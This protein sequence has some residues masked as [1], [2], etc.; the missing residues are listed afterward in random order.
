MTRGQILAR[1]EEFASIDERYFHNIRPRLFELHGDHRQYGSRE[2]KSLAEHLD[3]ACQFVLTVSRLANFPETERRCVLCAAA[4][5]DLNKIDSH[6]RSVKDLARTP[7]YIREQL[8]VLGISD[9]VFGDEIELLRKL[10]ERHSAHNVTDGAS[11]LPEPPIVKRLAA[12]VVAADLFDLSID[13]QRRFAKIEVELAV[14][15]QRRVRLFQIRISEDRG[16]LTSLLLNACQEIVEGYGLHTLSIDPDGFIVIGD[17]MPAE[18]LIPEIANRW[19]SKIDGV[20]GGSVEQ[21]VTAS[22]DGIKVDLQAV[23]LNPGDAI[24]EVDKRLLNKFSGYKAA[25]VNEDIKKWAAKAG[26]KA[27]DDAIELG[28]VPVSSAEEFAVSEGLK[29]CY[30]SYRRANLS[31]DEVWDRIS[32][33]TNMSSEK[34]QGLQPFEAQFGR[35]L[36]ATRAIRR[37]ILSENGENE[38]LE[39]PSSESIVKNEI[40]RLLKDSFSLRLNNESKE[41][42]SA[43]VS[44]ACSSLIQKAKQLLNIDD[45]PSSWHGNDELSSYIEADSRKRCSMG[46]TFGLSPVEEIVSSKVPIGTKVQSFSNRLPG[47]ALFEPKR[48][49][50]QFAALGY[51]LLQV[52]ANLPKTA[53]S[54]PIYLHFALPHRS[55]PSL[56]RVWIKFIE[57]LSE[58]NTE[59]GPVTVSSKELYKDLSLIF[60]GN[61][62]VGLGLPKNPDFVH[63][64]VFVP[65]T[66]GSDVNDS[67]ALLKSVRLA[68]EIALALDIGFPVVVSSNLE[69]ACDWNFFARIEGIPTTLKPLLG[70]GLYKR[71]G[72]L[73]DKDLQESHIHAEEV[74]D[75][76]RYLGLIAY[77]VSSPKKW[78]DCIY[79]LARAL[80]RPLDL[81]FVTFRWLLRERD[82]PNFQY[83]WNQINDPVTKL[84]ES[85]MS[86]EHILVSSYLR[87]AAEIAVEGKLWGSSFR[88][89]AQVEPFAE[90]MKAVRS[91]P[92]HMDWDTIIGSLVQQYHTR[93]DRIREHG[94]GKTKFDQLSKFYGVLRDFFEEVYNLRPDK[95]LSD[96][97]TLEAAYLFFLQE[98]RNAHK[99]ADAADED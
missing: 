6:G 25:K 70:S 57:G 69:L 5:H 82:D 73:S 50:T 36:F 2:G 83:I 52:G 55:C 1:K 59:G 13:Q 84:L 61:K 95:L 42:D 98:A 7:G 99:L 46:P 31:P 45:K 8:E 53:K 35:C 39:L 48:R 93:L 29:A 76:L 17:S 87:R 79:D 47:G 26:E 64:T 71:R 86:E 85:V 20:F 96:S 68:L 81:Y 90:F 19:Q 92:S 24:V 37:K 74:L 65:I 38:Y 88:R 72:Q 16:Y 54:P 49:A 21:L 91:R 40:P 34:R 30:L 66:W 15:F 14:A 44:L 58:T 33:L 10:I 28:L 32:E 41:G 9:L 27:L 77:A 94:V 51:Q 80:K 23:K 56:R 18:D 43:N 62:V 78:E 67:Q 11:F 63:S 4:I 75:R 3:S 12:L 22:K 89:T 60:K 97:K